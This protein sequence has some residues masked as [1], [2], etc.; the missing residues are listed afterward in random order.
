MKINLIVLKTAQSEK[1]AKFYGQLGIKFDQHRHGNGPLH[2]AA[3]VNGI[4]FE[5]YPLPKDVNIADNT[6]RL[7]FGVTSLDQLIEN[8]KK[9]AIK[10][11]KDPT[12]TEWGYQALIEDPDGRKIELRDEDIE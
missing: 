8:L 9:Q 1:L 4:T 11:I 5:I 12:I 10:V 7:G 2:F 6:L 3:Q